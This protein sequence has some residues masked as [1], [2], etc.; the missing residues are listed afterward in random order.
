MGQKKRRLGEDYWRRVAADSVLQTAG[1][2][3]INTYIDKRQETVS[4]WVDLR[5]IFKVFV[6]YGLQGGGGS[7]SRGGGRRHLNDI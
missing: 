3:P 6:R 5:P 4:E 1:K 2:K 7:R